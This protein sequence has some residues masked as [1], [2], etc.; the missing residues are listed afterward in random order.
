MKNKQ[1]SLLIISVLMI[2]SIGGVVAHDWRNLS[3]T[4]HQGCHNSGATES[5]TGTLV[6]PDAPTVPSGV[7]ITPSSKLSPGQ[8]FNASVIIANFT[9]ANSV[10][11][12]FPSESANVTVQISSHR[13]DNVDFGFGWEESVSD[14]KADS[15]Y[16]MMQEVVLD[17]SGNSS[18]I[19]FWLVA[20]S[21]SGYHTLVI[22]AISA[23]NN[24]ETPGVDRSIPII[25]AS[26]NITIY[27]RRVLLAAAGDDDDDRD[28]WKEAAIPGYLLIIT[29]GTIFA[30]SAVLILRIK[31]KMKKTSRNV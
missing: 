16:W 6:D 21:S 15:S 9:E 11:R 30:V 25:F 18:Q 14:D 8:R 10:D 4:G 17:A 19:D 20:P 31:K 7:K 1:I 5:A 12:K 29:L 23:I 13:G 28:L 2:A 22:D 24:S 26:A 3:G 27:V